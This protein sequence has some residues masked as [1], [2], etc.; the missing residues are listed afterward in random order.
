M[1]LEQIL[2]SQGFGT[3]HE[4]RGL[5]ALG[6]VAVKGEVVDDPDADID[7]ESRVRNG[8]GPTWAVRGKGRL[9][10]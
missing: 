6:Q 1:R 7:V 2:F 3:R 9:V 8:S 4:C 10:M 5:I